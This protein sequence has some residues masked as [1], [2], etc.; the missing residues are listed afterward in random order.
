MQCDEE[1][2]C[3]KENIENIRNWMN[4]LTGSGFLTLNKD[5][6][7][8]IATVCLVNPSKRNALDA[9]MMSQ[10]SHV[11]D[12]L[13]EWQKGKAVILYGSN[14]F[15][16]S[17]MDLQLAKYLKDDINKSKLMAV[18][19]RDTLLRLKQLPLLSVAFVE[20]RALGGGAELTTACDFRVLLRNAAIGF[21]HS[22]MG[23]TSAFGAGARLV[24]LIG[25]TKT[26]E[27]AASGKLIQAEEAIEIGFANI[28]VQDINEVKE[29]VTNRIVHSSKSIGIIK[30]VVY[31]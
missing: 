16:C 4:T 23:I 22:K 27:Y 1:E 12:E 6:T 29:W 7:S 11:V 14:G 26:L 25:T 21:V 30:S 9:P 28:I 18:L 5:D 19:M 2:L 17:G 20:G 13:K 3:T 10:F 8:G 24:Q 15:F 31:N